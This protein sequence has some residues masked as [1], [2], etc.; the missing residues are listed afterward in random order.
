MFYTGRAAFAAPSKLYVLGL[1][2]GGDPVAQATETVGAHCL[3]FREGPAWWSEYADESWCGARP[4][5]WGMQPRMLHMFASL[6]LDP[7][8]VPA[9]NVVFVRSSTEGTLQ[10]EKAVLLAAC[11]PIHR[12]VID[13]LA[14]RVLLCLGGTVGRWVRAELG[15]TELVD[16]YHETNQR[17]WRSEAHRAC[18]GRIVLTVTHPGRADWRNS[19]SDPTPLVQRALPQFER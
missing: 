8:A 14:V 4:G 17:R 18:D 6:G 13:A 2:P 15:A 9:S 7:H 16:Q 10:A 11:W 5:T 1:N 12:V 3:K 19:H